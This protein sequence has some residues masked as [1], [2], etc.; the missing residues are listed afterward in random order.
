MTE[1]APHV[2]RIDGPTSRAGS[3]ISSTMKAMLPYPAHDHMTA[4]IAAPRSP[5]FAPRKGEAK[6]RRSTS[7]L[8]ESDTSITSARKPT[9][10]SFSAASAFIIRDTTRRRKQFSTTTSRMDVSAMAFSRSALSPSLASKPGTRAPTTGRRYRASVSALN[11]CAPGP[12]T[13][14]AQKLYEKARRSPKAALM[15]A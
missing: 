4:T 2:M 8:R 13:K 6:L 3:A 7:V 14:K 11:A 15:Y 5:S 10:R 1:T 12:R 9:S